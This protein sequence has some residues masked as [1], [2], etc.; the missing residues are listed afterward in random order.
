MAVRAVI[1]FLIW[2]YDPTIIKADE[3]RYRTHNFNYFHAYISR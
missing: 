2:R 1:P 3:S